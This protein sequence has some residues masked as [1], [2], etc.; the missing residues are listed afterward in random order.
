MLCVNEVVDERA[1]RRPEERAEH[2]RAKI[3]AKID[4]PIARDG[5]DRPV[6]HERCQDGH[7]CGNSDSK[8]PCGHQNK[9]GVDTEKY[10]D[11]DG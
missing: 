6:G 3:G 1:D 10:D 7:A 2:H 9:R 11:K 5:H 8:S 4:E